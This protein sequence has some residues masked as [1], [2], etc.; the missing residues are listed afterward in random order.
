MACAR[1][2]VAPGAASTEAALQQEASEFEDRLTRSPVVDQD[3]IEASVDLVYRLAHRIAQACSA[4]TPLD[5]ALL[6][7]GREHGGDAR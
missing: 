5:R 6:L 1:G 3:A 7:I 2:G 4:P